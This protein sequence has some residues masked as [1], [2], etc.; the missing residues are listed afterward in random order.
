MP[1]SAFR[2]RC[3]KNKGLI[4]PSTWKKTAIVLSSTVASIWEAEI[5][6]KKRLPDWSGGGDIPQ[7]SSGQDLGVALMGDGGWEQRFLQLE[8]ITT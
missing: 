5:L 8:G 1:W 7:G 4:L 3:H 6:L 2:L